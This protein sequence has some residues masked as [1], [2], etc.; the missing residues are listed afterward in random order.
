MSVTIIVTNIY[1]ELKIIK[2]MHGA[3]IKDVLY[4]VFHDFTA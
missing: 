3:T 4:R 1:V 2:K